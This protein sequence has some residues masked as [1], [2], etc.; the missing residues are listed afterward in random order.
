ML[1]RLAVQW[2]QSCVPVFMV[3]YRPFIQTG[4]LHVYTQQYLSQTAQA[5]FYQGATIEMSLI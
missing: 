4:N 2:T 3:R 5:S 1:S